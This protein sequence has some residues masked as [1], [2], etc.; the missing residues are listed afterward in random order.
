[1]N[2]VRTTDKRSA[3]IV[4]QKKAGSKVEGN[5]LVFQKKKKKK[6]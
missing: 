2:T 6:N 4:R 5:G 1:M 3:L